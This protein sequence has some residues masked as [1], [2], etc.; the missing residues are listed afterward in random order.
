M[1]RKRNIVRT[2]TISAA[3]VSAIIALEN[4]ALNARSTSERLSDAVARQAGTIWFI[5]AHALWFV[6]WILLNTG[7]VPGIRAFDPY[8]YQFLTF[9]VSLEAIFLSLF[10]LMSQNRSSRQAD[11]RGHLD[12]QINLLAEQESTKM[13]QMLQ[14]LCK[15]HGLPEAHDAELEQLKQATKPEELLNELKKSLPGEC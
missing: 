12:L 4:E 7:F 3:N 15:H 10:I 9:V 13:L 11:A 6:F 14:G 5:S 2:S 8:P 1:P